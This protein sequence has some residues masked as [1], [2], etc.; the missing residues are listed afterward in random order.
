MIFR[1]LSERLLSHGMPAMCKEQNSNVSKNTLQW[2][3]RTHHWFNVQRTSAK[4]VTERRVSKRGASNTTTE[5]QGITD[6][7]LLLME[8]HTGA[9]GQQISAYSFEA[10]ISKVSVDGCELEPP[11]PVRVDDSFHHCTLP[12]TTSA[13]N[14]NAHVMI[15]IHYD[16][17]R[18]S[19]EIGVT[20]ITLHCW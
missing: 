17:G 16:G 9:G 7:I 5:K 2:I 10:L 4:F 20:S 18:Q 8:R 14:S 11:A 15:I 1:N 12:L 13:A 3:C 19:L 6:H